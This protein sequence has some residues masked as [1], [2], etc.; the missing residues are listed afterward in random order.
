MCILCCR[1]GFGQFK[2]NTQCIREWPLHLALKDLQFTFS[3]FWIQMHGL[4]P[5]Q[6]NSINAKAIG[7]LIGQFVEVD[8][9]QKGVVGNPS[10]LSLVHS[11]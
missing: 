2:T 9:V 8:L 4:A 5:N 1:I 10:H 6:M 7:N 3:P 11:S